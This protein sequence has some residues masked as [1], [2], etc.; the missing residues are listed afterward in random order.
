MKRNELEE[1][2]A[3]INRLYHKGLIAE[4]AYRESLQTTCAKIVELLRPTLVDFSYPHEI[5]TAAT[6]EG[7]TVLDAWLDTQR[8]FRA[9]YKRL[10]DRARKVAVEMQ[11]TPPYSED[12]LAREE[13]RIA[14]RESYWSRC[15]AIEKRWSEIGVS[16]WLERDTSVEE[17]TQEESQLTLQE[18]LYR[19]YRTASAAYKIQGLTPKELDFPVSKET[20]AEFEEGI[21]FSQKWSSEIAKHKKQLLW[22]YRARITFPKAPYSKEEITAYVE[23]VRPYL[24]KSRFYK[25]YVPILVIVVVVGLGW[26]WN[27]Y[28][29][30]QGFQDRV[31]VVY[32]Q[33]RD[34]KYLEIPIGRLSEVIV[35]N[36][37]QDALEQLALY[38]RVRGVSDVAKKFGIDVPSGRLLESAVEYYEKAVKDQISRPT[39][40][41]LGIEGALI[42][43]GS[44]TMGCTQEQG[45][46]CY[47][48][49]KPSHD[50]Q[51]GHSFYMMKTE[52]TQGLC[53]EL[54]GENPSRFTDC[55]ENCPVESVSWYDAVRFA[56]KLS[57]RVGLEPC[58]KI[59]KGIKPAVQWISTK[60]VGWR[61]PTEAEWEYAARGGQD[62]KYAGSNNIDEVAWYDGN[63]GGKT[64]P[65][66]EKKENGYGLYDM[67][68]NVWEWVWDT[69]DHN[70]YE[71]GDVVD[72]IVD[73]SSPFRVARGGSWSYYARYARV[74]SR[75]GYDASNRINFRGFRFL[76]TP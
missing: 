73:V 25:R 16:K 32:D 53:K 24:A 71:R 17:L 18:E 14:D 45:D 10:S 20:I 5:P 27:D 50:V 47:D 19:R 67:S 4:E 11:C 39:E 2:L 72:P 43:S 74:S 37:E 55:G 68:G 61:L 29:E 57:A 3:D 44:F 49:E 70:A 48:S 26:L 8:V 41:K 51:I 28:Q 66:G 65:V 75:N 15:I 42:P 46:D 58:Y 13:E 1:S 76:R 60:C 23:E 22:L 59:G 56:N 52:V 40:M 33:T 36:Y 7:I 64:H 30:Q 12:E 6:E 21:N 31:E 35:S 62:F 54:M 38:K 63:S 69:Y 34:L 9:R